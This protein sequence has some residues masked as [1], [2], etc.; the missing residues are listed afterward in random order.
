MLTFKLKKVEQR[1]SKKSFI[2]KARVAK[3]NFKENWELIDR[4]II[5]K[6]KSNWLNTSIERVHASVAARI[7][8][9]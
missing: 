3:I 4:R 1:N 5:N 9:A 2:C 6:L 7:V 8:S